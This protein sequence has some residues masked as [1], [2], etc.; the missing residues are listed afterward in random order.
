[1]PAA[2]LTSR[3][4]HREMEGKSH[5][6]FRDNCL[7]STEDQTS[8]PKNQKREARPQLLERRPQRCLGS[9]GAAEAVYGGA[10][11]R[12]GGAE[13]DRAAGSGGGD[14]GGGGAGAGPAEG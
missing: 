14:E 2:S 11:G 6:P 1:M 4:S 5:K 10:G 9:E 12:G 8:L 7:R 13:E 3:A